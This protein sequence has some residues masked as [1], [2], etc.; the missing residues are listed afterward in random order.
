MRAR[1]PESSLPLCQIQEKFPLGTF[2][3][4]R[5]VTGRSCARAV[6]NTNIQNEA[7]T[8]G[9]TGKCLQAHVRY[10][11]VL[12]YA[13]LAVKYVHTEGVKED[14]DQ[15]QGCSKSVGYNITICSV[16]SHA[17]GCDTGSVI[18]MRI[19]WIIE[20][21]KVRQSLYNGPLGGL[22]RSPRDDK[23]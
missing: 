7:Q 21:K 13:V 14:Q 10:G 8:D 20:F 19:R 11:S 18:N 12:A 22:C 23:L 17:G 3:I 15:D 4:F 1:G 5:E 2:F 9:D 16:I 6:S